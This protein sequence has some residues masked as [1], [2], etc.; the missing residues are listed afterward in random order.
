MTANRV[1]LGLLLIAAV[2]YYG[3]I[4][5]E[6]QAAKKEMARVKQAQQLQQQAQPPR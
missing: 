2:L 6:E 4:Y 3:S 5:R 1:F